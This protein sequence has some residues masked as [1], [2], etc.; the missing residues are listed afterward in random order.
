MA[1]V[2]I[3]G[4]IVGASH[5]PKHSLF[6]KWQ[7]HYGNGW[8]LI[9]GL[10]EGQTHVDNPQYDEKAYWS[11]PVDIHFA[12]KGIQG[13]PKFHVQV[14]HLDHWGRSE[15]YGYGF[16]HVPASAGTHIVD[17]VTWRPV[18]TLRDQI[19]QYF[20]GGGPQLKNIELAYCG[21]DRY[22]LQTETMGIVHME[23]GI[24]LRHFDKFGVEFKF[25]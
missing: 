17:C 20:V 19:R 4:Q 5:F 3:I 1:E 6:C 2:H 10:K 12:T 25:M 13:W 23:L 11:H 8:R 18:G 22:R 24:I 14:Y 9:S 15:L 7:I 21:Y 16:C